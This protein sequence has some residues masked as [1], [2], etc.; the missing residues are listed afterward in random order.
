MAETSKTSFTIPA[1]HP[2]LPG[3]FPGNPVVPGVVL[4]EQVRSALVALHPGLII[5]ELPQVKFRQPLRA[6]TEAVIELSLDHEKLRFS[7]HTT[8]GE[9]IA[10]GRARCRLQAPE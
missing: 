7:C 2:S 4:L 3:H 6:A 1:D 10:D 8:N 5:V 9:L